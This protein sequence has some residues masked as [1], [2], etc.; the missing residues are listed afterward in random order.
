MEEA[1]GLYG[2]EPMM[3]NI[4]EFKNLMPTRP[5]EIDNPDYKLV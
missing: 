4:T 2:I 3:T 1:I 5:F